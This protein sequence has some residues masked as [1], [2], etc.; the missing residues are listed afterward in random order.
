ML[1]GLRIN[2][3][4]NGN[5]YVTKPDFNAGGVAFYEGGAKKPEVLEQ[6]SFINAVLGK[7]ELVVTAEQALVVTQILEG[8]YESAKTGKPVYFN[9]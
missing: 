3:V 7:A 5:Q 1:D 8:I 6:L 4:K 9:D 2:G